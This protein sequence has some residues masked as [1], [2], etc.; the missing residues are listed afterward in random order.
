MGATGHTRSLVGSRY[1]ETSE[2]ELT[3]RPGINKV[4]IKAMA[5]STVNICVIIL[6]ALLVCPCQGRAATDTT[7]VPVTVG[8]FFEIKLTTQEAYSSSDL[9]DVGYGTASA[10]V[11][12]STHEMTI[13]NAG[14]Y[15][16]KSNVAWVLSMSRSDNM[17]GAGGITLKMKTDSQPWS[18]SFVTSTTPFVID[19]G[20]ADNGNGDLQRENFDM[21]LTGLSMS[22]PANNYVETMYFTLEAQ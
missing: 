7:P 1:G 22:T 9:V 13:E 11:L 15:H 6:A 8:Q 14:W 19:A 2:P 10:T 21:R 4:V 18:Q 5:Q 20:P 16:I 3:N 12:N 17:F